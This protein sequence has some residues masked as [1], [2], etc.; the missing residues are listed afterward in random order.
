MRDRSRGKPRSKLWLLPRGTGRDGTAAG[1][2]TGAPASRPGGAG[3]P[4]PAGG[5]L[6]CMTL[7]AIL[8]RVIWAVRLTGLAG[9]FGERLTQLV[10]RVNKQNK[11]PL[12]SIQAGLS[13]RRRAALKAQRSAC[14]CQR[15]SRGRCKRQQSASLFLFLIKSSPFVRGPRH[16]CSFRN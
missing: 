4:I 1:L 8:Q 7:V 15:D 5:G 10:G 3:D 16:E 11:P 6:V 13:S 14:G 12:S 2:G 9:L